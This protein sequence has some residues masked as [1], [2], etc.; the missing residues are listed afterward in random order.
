MTYTIYDFHSMVRMSSISHSPGHL[1]VCGRPVAL[2]EDVVITVDGDG[3]SAHEIDVLLPP[4]GDVVG[5]PP[6]PQHQ[7]VL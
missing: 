1:S 4:V 5:G 6:R 3:V 7:Q 2:V